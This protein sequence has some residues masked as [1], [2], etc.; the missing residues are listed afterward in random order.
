M[1][2]DFAESF[3]A[4]MDKP[5][6]PSDER[7]L[8]Q[9]RLVV[10]PPPRPTPT[11]P[12]ALDAAEAAARRFYGYPE[13]QERAGDAVGRIPPR[14]SEAAQEPP[15]GPDGP[16]MQE[17]HE[18][19]RQAEAARAEALFGDL[20]MGDGVRY[21]EPEM[22]GPREFSLE[23]PDDLA[24]NL[25][26]GE[27]AQITAAF[28]ESGVGRTMANDLVRQGIEASRRGPLTDHQIQQRNVA[29]MAALTAKWGDRT[30]A[31]LA[32]AKAMV[33]E[34]S[35]KWPGLPDYLQHTGLGSD[36][37]LIQQLVA[38][39]ERRPGRR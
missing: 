37:K 1:D 20:P 4:T 13:P 21:D 39:A 28:I 31:K 36:P 33:R 17:R 6:P 27:A 12:D 11:G 15:G 32:L 18:Q 19:F 14:T 34:A 10:A 2:D 3:Y 5:V 38:R 7:L 22:T 23:V 26:E 25:G 8:A 9:D 35:A 16:S 29:G 30:P 24:A